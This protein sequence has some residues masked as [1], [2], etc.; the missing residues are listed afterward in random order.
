MPVLVEAFSVITRKD[1]IEDFYPDGM[2]GFLRD[3][4]NRTACFDD[5]L[6]RVGFMDPDAV[7]EFVTS[8]GN[9][10]LVHRD[11]HGD[12]QDLVVVS[13]GQ[14]PTTPCDW[15]E[16]F[17]VNVGGAN[18]EICRLAG[19][20]SR[21]LVCPG[22]WSHDKAAIPLVY[23]PTDEMESRMEFLREENG[24]TVCR[25]RVTGKI[26]YSPS[27]KM[28]RAAESTERHDSPTS[29]IRSRLWQSLCGLFRGR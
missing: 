1:R 7:R 14:G 28:A 4:P 2:E 21:R 13:Q 9:H 3:C 27:T 20:D 5:H 8:L 23:V 24:L 19:T 29:E 25:D 10:G 12:A 18:V 6:V 26:M 16:F 15:A 22:G 11:E 17:G